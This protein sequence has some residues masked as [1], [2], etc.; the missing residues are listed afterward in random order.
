[1]L[2]VIDP[3]HLVSI[4]LSIWQG[5]VQFGLAPKLRKNLTN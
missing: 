4:S 3:P 1:M 2:T 5:G